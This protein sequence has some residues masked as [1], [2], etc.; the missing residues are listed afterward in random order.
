MMLMMIDDVDVDVDQDDHEDDDDDDD[1]ND[2]DDSP[3]PLTAAAPPISLLRSTFGIFT[4]AK[5]KPR[6]RSGRDSTQPS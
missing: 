6:R 1:E 4:A 3:P 2:D 5:S